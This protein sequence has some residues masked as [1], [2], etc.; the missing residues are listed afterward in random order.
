M[1]SKKAVLGMTPAKSHMAGRIR[2]GGALPAGM[3][4]DLLLSPG[5]LPGRVGKR[6]GP[7]PLL[8][9]AGGAV[10]SLSGTGNW[11]RR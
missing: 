2:C 3:D 10:D 5:F 9:A 6:T 7:V 8:L 11:S 1:V 4:Q